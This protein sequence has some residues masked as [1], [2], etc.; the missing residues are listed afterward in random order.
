M[1]SEKA[2]NM[3][4]AETL[5]RFYATHGRRASLLRHGATTDKKVPCSECGE[6]KS[7]WEAVLPTRSLYYCSQTCFVDSLEE[8]EAKVPD[9]VIHSEWMA[10]FI[11]PTVY[12]SGTVESSLRELFPA[13]QEFY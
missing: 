12:S 5:S 4:S 1:K 2:H 13:I 11:G 8:I 3:P 6:R 10:E 7:R 9:E